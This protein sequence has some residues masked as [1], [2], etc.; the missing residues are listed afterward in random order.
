LR[1]FQI[2]GWLRVRLEDVDAW[3]EGQ[4]YDPHQKLRLEEP[5]RREGRAAT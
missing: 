4:K 3:L 1:A 2:G 5:S